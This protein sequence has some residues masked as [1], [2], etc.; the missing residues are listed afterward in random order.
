MGTAGQNG[1]VK[2]VLDQR[3]VKGTKEEK[4]RQRSDAGR[5]YAEVV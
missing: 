1:F 3:V 2:R 4:P 5:C